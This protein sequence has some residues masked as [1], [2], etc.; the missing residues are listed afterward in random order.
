MFTVIDFLFLLM[1]RK[2]ALSGIDL[3]LGSL[4][5]AHGGPHVRESSP[6]RGFSTLMISALRNGLIVIIIKN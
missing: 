2:Y 3:S 4:L 5:D 6:C 1:A